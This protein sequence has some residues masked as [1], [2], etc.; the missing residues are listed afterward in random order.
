[1]TSFE[2]NISSR[3]GS[4]RRPGARDAA[5][6][7]FLSVIAAAT[8]AV[9][10]AI[11][12][13]LVLESAP[14]LGSVGISGL[15]TGA[16]WRPVE[17]AFDLS[18]MLT[19]SFVV[20]LGA[21]LVAAPLGLGSALFCRFYAPPPLAAVYRRLVAV[22]AGVP[23]VVYGLWG[24]T[25]LV[26]L[27]GRIAPP[28]PSL[29]SAIA[30]LAIM[31]VPTI[32]IL[33]DAA[34][35][36]VPGQHAM[37]ASALGLSTWGTVQAVLPAARSG[38]T[39]SVLLAAGRAIG[40]TVAVLMVAGNVVRMPG[41]LFDPFRTLTANIALEMGYALGDHRSALFASGLVLTLAVI[42]LMIAADRAGAR[43]A[44]E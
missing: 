40:E 30:I 11:V 5:L 37:S 34:I 43:A 24:L 39:T 8:A 31:I 19:G 13:F 21:V 18:P 15:F 1:M 28:G 20:T 6:R 14:F 4:D 27:V 12:I 3:S 36:A 9:L 10:V 33:S 16:V 38:I 29:L 7:R 2:R 32:A 35:G 44:H 22:A 26:P 23:S 25:V 17:G 41:G 42:A